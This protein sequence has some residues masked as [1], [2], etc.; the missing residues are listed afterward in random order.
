MVFGTML[1]EL[2]LRGREKRNKDVFLLEGDDVAEDEFAEKEFTQEQTRLVDSSERMISEREREIKELM[3]SLI[4][5]SEIFKELQVLVID[6]GSILDRIDFNMTQV[7]AH[8]A[9]AV[10]QLQEV[11]R[12][13]VVFVLSL[14]S[15]F[16]A[17]LERQLSEEISL[18]PLYYCVGCDGYHPNH[19]LV[20]KSEIN[21]HKYIALRFC[22]L[23]A[24]NKIH[25]DHCLLKMKRLYTFLGFSV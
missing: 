20:F 4:S 6:Q 5:L 18:P 10:E 11:C 24:L 19:H 2:E 14:T 3:K 22:C 12:F 21:R 13:N 17:W 7:T 25:S 1:S 15:P 16:F 23:F 9:R 8:T